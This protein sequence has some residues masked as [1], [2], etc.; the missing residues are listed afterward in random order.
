MFG[1]I[2]MESASVVFRILQGFCQNFRLG[3]SV[4]PAQAGIQFPGL[5][6]P[7]CVGMTNPKTK[8]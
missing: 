6:V 1:E 5:W 3:L 4:I 8:G 2:A 7:A